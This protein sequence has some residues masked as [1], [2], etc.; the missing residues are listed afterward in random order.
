MQIFDIEL[1]QSK[2]VS[3]RQWRH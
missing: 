1:T 3:Y 2:T